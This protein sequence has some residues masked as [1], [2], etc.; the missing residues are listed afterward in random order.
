MSDS[1]IASHFSLSFRIVYQKGVR[2][3][4]LF[5]IIYH[6]VSLSVCYRKRDKNRTSD[7]YISSPFSS[8]LTHSTPKMSWAVF[9]VVVC[10]FA[11]SINKQ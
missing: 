3:S 8:V 9:F 5:Y 7:T 11:S 2:Q 6:S 10:L 1:Y 4:S